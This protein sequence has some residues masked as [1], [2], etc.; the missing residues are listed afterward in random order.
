[1]KKISK[2]DIEG[3]LKLDLEKN[4]DIAKEI[5]SKKSQNQK[6]VGF[7]LGD[8]DLINNAK[9]KLKDKKLDFIV[10]NEITTALN[11]DKNKVTIIDKND[12][13]TNIDT[14][15]KENIARKILEVVCD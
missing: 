11:T 15:T 12:K 5:A 3:D 1:M 4:P 7:C 9:R 14:D 6:I 2:E 10:A 8:D 13:I